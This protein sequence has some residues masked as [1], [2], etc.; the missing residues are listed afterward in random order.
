MDII[1]DCVSTRIILSYYNIIMLYLRTLVNNKTITTVFQLC[2]Y[3]LYKQI[4]ET[5]GIINT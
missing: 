2:V 3:I 5:H 4:F 1:I